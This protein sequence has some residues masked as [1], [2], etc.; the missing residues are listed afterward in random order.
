MAPVETYP[1][2]SLAASTLLPRSLTRDFIRFGGARPGHKSP[3]RREFSGTGGG[4]QFIYQFQLR[5]GVAHN[6]VAGL[7]QLRRVGLV[8]A[9]HEVVAEYHVQRRAQ[10]MQNYGDEFIFAADRKSTRLN[11]SNLGL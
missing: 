9:Q 10:R 5:P 4:E 3:Y 7:F 8:L 11:Y 1:A 6:D 2:L